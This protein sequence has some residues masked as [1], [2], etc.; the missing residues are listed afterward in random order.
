MK[1]MI[2]L[3]R[4]NVAMP[5]KSFEVIAALKETAEIVKSVT[6]VEVMTFGS[7]GSHVGE[8]VSVSNYTSLADFEEKA[9]K[10]LSNAKYQAAIK[11]FEGLLVPGASHDH[12]L[13]QV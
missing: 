10:L 13:R 5:G 8:Y 1:A 9:T 7:M 11:K 2:R 12:F 3:A 4:I 6:G